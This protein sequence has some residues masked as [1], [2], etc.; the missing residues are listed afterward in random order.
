MPVEGGEMLFTEVTLAVERPIFGPAPEV[1]ILRIAGGTDGK[2]R[3]VVGEMPQFELNQRYLLF[4]R[5]GYAGV[6]DPITG[7]NQGF[8]RIVADP[9]SGSDMLL[10]ARGDIVVAVENSQV[11]VRHS[12]AV[13]GPS[14]AMGPAP[15]PQSGVV[16]VAEPSPEAMR[17]WASPEPAMA[18]DDFVAAATELKEGAL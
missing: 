7:V 10:D 13:H 8:Y 9:E 15:Q 16:K 6:A 12:A 17:Y 3:V 5:P 1:V 4:L 11:V 14:P 2:V 18:I